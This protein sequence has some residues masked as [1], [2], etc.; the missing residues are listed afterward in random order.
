MARD[1]KYNRTIHRYFHQ[2]LKRCPDLDEY[3]TLKSILIDVA[4]KERDRMRT[5][6]KERIRN[7][8]QPICSKGLGEQ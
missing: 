8:K 4:K 1:T 3:N 7:G 5:I 6:I 2:V